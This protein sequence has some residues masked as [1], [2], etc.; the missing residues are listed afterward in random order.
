MDYYNLTVF[1]LVTTELGAQG[2]VCAG[3]R[4][5]GLIEQIGGKAARPWAGRWAWSASWNC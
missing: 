2:T 3:G 5:D 4:Y 1:E